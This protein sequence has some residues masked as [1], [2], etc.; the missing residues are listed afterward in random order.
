MSFAFVTAFQSCYNVNVF[1]FSL[2]WRCGSQNCSSVHG[3][4]ASAQVGASK[5]VRFYAVPWKL[6]GG[7]DNMPT[8][9]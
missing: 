5:V 9:V 1:S 6:G 7:W 8:D 3:R 4:E 2:S